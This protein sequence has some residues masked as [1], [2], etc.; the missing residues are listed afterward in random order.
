MLQF[1]IDIERIDCP[2]MP[3]PLANGD[4]LVVAS[5]GL[6]FLDDETIRA[7]IAE[8]SDAPS[9][10]IADALFSAIEA[11]GD[12]EQ[13]NISFAVIKVD[14]AQPGVAKPTD[15]ALEA[16]PE[17]EPDNIV[18]VPEFEWAEANMS[19]GALPIFFPGRPRRSKDAEN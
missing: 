8:N 1:V 3:F 14:F 15:D 9:S 11:L 13:D 18:R 2:N 10:E 7:I 19:V 17:G 6:Q 5:D 4:I 12:P 16:A